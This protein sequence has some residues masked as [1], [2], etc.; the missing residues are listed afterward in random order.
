MVQRDG[1]TFRRDDFRHN[2]YSQRRF[3]WRPYVPPRGWYSHRW[4]FGEILPPI[5][6]GRD[7]WISDFWQFGLPIPPA[8]YVWVRYGEDALLVDRNTGEILEVIYGVFY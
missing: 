4:L 7:Y 8:G 6:W 3:H 2:Y 5:F 1:R